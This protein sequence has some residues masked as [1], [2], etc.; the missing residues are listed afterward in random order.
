MFPF[1]QLFVHQR[2]PIVRCIVYICMLLFIANTHARVHTRGFHSVFISSGADK[3]ALY[4]ATTSVDKQLI[5]E[6][7]NILTRTYT[8][9]TISFIV[10]HYT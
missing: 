6:T 10:L 5:V 8:V 7:Q 1:E 4:S 9:Q 2:Q 3:T